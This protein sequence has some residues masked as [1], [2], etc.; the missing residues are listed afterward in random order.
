MLIATARVIASAALNFVWAQWE[1]RVKI[2]A[3]SRRLK[4]L[5]SGLLELLMVT[6][7]LESLEWRF[8]T[9]E[10]VDFADLVMFGK[11]LYLSG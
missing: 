8:I 9:L 5:A 1:I 10:L 11:C 4:A 2:V 3:P 6:E 7:V